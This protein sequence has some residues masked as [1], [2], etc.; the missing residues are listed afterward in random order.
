M[1]KII[2]LLLTVAMVLTMVPAVVFADD[3]VAKIGD[4]GY[5]T[6]QM[7]FNAAQAGDTIEVLQN[8]TESIDLTLLSK[9][10]EL[11]YF[12]NPQFIEGKENDAKTYAAASGVVFVMDDKNSFA[13]TYSYECELRTYNSEGYDAQELSNTKTIFYGDMETLT[14]RYA[15]DNKNYSTSPKVAGNGCW[16]ET[17]L[18]TLITTCI[19]DGTRNYSIIMPNRTALNALNTL[20]VEKDMILSTYSGTGGRIDFR[21]MGSDAFTLDLNG[22]EIYQVSGDNGT[23]IAHTSDGAAALRLSK[24]TNMTIVDSSSNKT[25]SVVGSLAAVDYYGD[26]ISGNGGVLTFESGKLIGRMVPSLSGSNNDNDTNSYQDKNEKGCIIRID[27]NG[28]FVMNGGAL[29][30]DRHE[31]RRESETKLW[32]TA[33]AIQVTQECNNAT[34]TLNGGSIELMP[35]DQQAPTNKET[36]YPEIIYRDVDA[37]VT[38]TVADGVKFYCDNAVAK[39]ESDNGVQYFGTLKAAFEKANSMDSATITMIADTTFSY[40]SKVYT[41]VESGKDITL[42]LAGKVITSSGIGAGDQNSALIENKGTLT[43]KDSAEKQDGHFSGKII[44]AADPTWEYGGNGDYSSSYQSNLIYNNPGTLYVKGGYL[45]NASVAGSNGGAAYVIDNSSNL[46][47]SSTIIDDG[48]LVAA[49]T[50]IRLFANTIAENNVTVNGGNIN[51]KRNDFMLH[52]T[53]ANNKANLIINEGTFTTVKKGDSGISAPVQLWQ[54]GNTTLAN[55]SITGGKFEAQGGATQKIVELD[56]VEDTT[57]NEAKKAI[58]ISGGYYTKDVSEYVADGY[59]CIDNEDF[60]TKKDYPYIVTVAT[61]K[62]DVNPDASKI[63]NSGDKKDKVD[64]NVSTVLAGEVKK[65]VV[66]DVIENASETAK[67]DIQEKITEDKVIVKEN[68]NPE[69]TK[70][71][72]L[73]ES[74]KTRI[75]IKLESLQIEV[76][77][78]KETPAIVTECTVTTKTATYE[79]KPVVTVTTTNTETGYTTVETFVITN[80][81]LNNNNKTLTFTLPIPDTMTGDSVLVKHIKEN[82]NEETFNNRVQ[83]KDSKRFITISATEFSTY[84]LSQQTEE[85]AVAKIVSD[86][87]TYYYSSLANAVKDV[88]DNDTIILLNN[89]ESGMIAISREVEFVIKNNGYTNNATICAETGYNDIGHGDIH[90]IVKVYCVT[91]NTNEAD[92]V[93][94]DMKV[95]PGTYITLPS[96]L[97][98]GKASLVGWKLD[99]KVYAPG[100]QFEV[101]GNVE[102]TAVWAVPATPIDCYVKFE[103]NGAD[104]VVDDMKV[105]PGTYITLPSGLTKDAKIFK[106]WKL[107]DTVYAAGSQYQ[108]KGNVTFV[109]EWSASGIDPLKAGLIGAGIGAAVVGTTAIVGNILKDRIED[110]KAVEPTTSAV[111][112]LSDCDKGANCPLSQFNDLNATKWYHDGI[113]YCVENGLINGFPGNV[114]KPNGNITRAQLLTIMWRLADKPVVNYAL[115]ASDVVN[116]EF[117]SWY[118][119]AVRWAKAEGISSGASEDFFGPNQD[120]T[121]EEF[122]S[123]LYNY[124]KYKGLDTANV[125]ANVDALKFEDFS[126]VSERDAAGMYYCIGAGVIGGDDKGKINPKSTATRAEAAAMLQRFCEG[127]EK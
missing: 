47:A 64:T 65:G 103:T 14:E 22:H 24:F 33:A 115:T 122:A 72:E 54:T 30:I 12:F 58:K 100:N 102:F 84:E 121:R 2:S 17:G 126:L 56:F 80:E 13:S 11:I 20:V 116:D 98:K 40:E 83:I 113:H 117:N 63:T 99:N 93:V 46:G 81:W 48:E 91:F 57:G 29:D 1:K 94:D 119:E 78:T 127:I 71:V 86:G 39:I 10:N 18:I 74:T 32:K 62:V 41:T 76:G 37:T 42:D 21:L 7:A 45:E 79:V 27:D 73:S 35:K 19:K 107:G 114:F 106:G 34:I 6:L 108:V 52:V 70:E 16:K 53:N 68:Q 87:K 96:G 82:G 26:Y 85:G 90:K 9:S 95:V 38:K 60:K 109:A 125:I 89:S 51:A 50:A 110:S 66:E 111:P 5:E 120:L 23:G 101:T 61:T 59:V 55:V 31:Y 67:S 88:Q 3:Y 36:E 124:A 104:Q 44:H 105:V 4:V 69:Q 8:V 92:Q 77:S 118:L 43:I 123:I 15:K 75:D 28:T 25:G 112:V 49:W 97:T